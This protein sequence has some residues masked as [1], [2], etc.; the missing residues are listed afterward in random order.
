MPDTSTGTYAW[1]IDHTM[2]VDEHDDTKLVEESDPT[3]SANGTTGPYDAPIEL[4]ERLARGEGRVWRTLYD[5]D[6]DG[7]PADQ[8]VCHIGRYLD[9]GIVDTGRAGEV[10]C[11]ADFGPLTDFSRGDSGAVDIQYQQD[12]GTWKTI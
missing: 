2:T 12:D 9:V 11:D 4:L 8:R 10:D 5:V 1:I 7:H 3:M 6:Y